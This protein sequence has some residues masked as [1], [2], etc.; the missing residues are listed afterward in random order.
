[1]QRTCA[2]CSR[3]A[4]H[5]RRLRMPAIA[6]AP[7]RVQHAPHC[8]KLMAAQGRRA[9]GLRPF[10]GGGGFGMISHGAQRVVCAVVTKGDCALVTLGGGEQSSFAFVL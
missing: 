7:S 3:T 1:M 9:R 5:C 8:E 2:A 10:G 4:G 6:A